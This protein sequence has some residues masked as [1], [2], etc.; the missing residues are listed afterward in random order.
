M[1]ARVSG[2]FVLFVFVFFLSGLMVPRFE[3]VSLGSFRFGSDR[4]GRFL[5]S[6]VKRSTWYRDEQETPP[7]V[8]N[9]GSAL[10]LPF[11]SSGGSC[12]ARARTSDRWD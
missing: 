10:C 8:F 11:D 1:Q 2:L 9:P 7:P 5:C 6:R 12:I 3:W 4:I